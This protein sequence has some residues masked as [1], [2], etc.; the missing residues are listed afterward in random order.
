MDP[1]ALCNSA[2]IYLGTQRLLNDGSRAQKIILTTAL[3]TYFH[4]G[5]IDGASGKDSRFLDL[6]AQAEAAVTVQPK[7]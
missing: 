1:L 5:S 6:G 4:N 7:P 3:R 2:V